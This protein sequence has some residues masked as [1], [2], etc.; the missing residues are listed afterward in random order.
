MGMVLYDTQGW[1]S[2]LATEWNSWEGVGGLDI[3]KRAQ[4]KHWRAQLSCVL[5]SSHTS[6][7]TCQ[8]RSYVSSGNLQAAS[9]QC[10]TTHFVWEVKE[11]FRLKQ[12]KDGDGKCPLIPLGV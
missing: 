9:C 8:A 12:A 11:H 5:P 7:H 6:H 4:G 2:S 1:V 3:S 10:L